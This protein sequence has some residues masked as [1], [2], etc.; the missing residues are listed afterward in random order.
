[1]RNLQGDIIA[2]ANADGEVV[3]EYSYDPWGKIDYHF[4]SNDAEENEALQM[5]VGIFCPLTYRGYNYDFTTGLYYLQSRYY[6]PEWGRFLNVDDTSVLLATQGEP[7]NANLFAYCNNN[8]VNNIDPTG[9]ECEQLI[10]DILVYVLVPMML[11]LLKFEELGLSYVL[12]SPKATCQVLYDPSGVLIYRFHIVAY[13]Q[14]SGYYY[15]EESFDFS[16]YYG[17]Y[18][19]WLNAL[20]NSKRDSIK[21]KLGAFAGKQFIKRVSKYLI[22]SSIA[23]SGISSFL[24]WAVS[25]TSFSPLDQHFKREKNF[26][27]ESETYLKKFP[28]SDP[29]YANT[30][31]FAFS[32]IVVVAVNYSGG[33]NR[34]WEAY[35]GDKRIEA[36]I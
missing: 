25:K 8:P 34:V 30:L 22:G 17:N 12:D 19:A 31:F 23:V 7:H 32:P 10:H 33:D 6:N 26:R 4:T 24:A 13:E 29:N 9:Y 11:V 3:I 21:M 14:G 1:M 28:K 18:S 2:V 36:L 16:L 20:D 35:K 27:K 15:T 5:L